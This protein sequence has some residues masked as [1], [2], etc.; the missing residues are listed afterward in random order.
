MHKLEFSP[1]GR[2]E[3]FAVKIV[4]SLAVGIWACLPVDVP[5]AVESQEVAS[6]ASTQNLPVPVGAQ[7]LDRSSKRP[8]VTAFRIGEWLP[9][10]RSLDPQRLLDALQASQLREMG[11]EEIQGRIAA[12][13]QAFRMQS[14]VPSLQA[15]GELESLLSETPPN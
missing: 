13:E 8:P 10:K 3:I 12:Y 5:R 14:L 6:P 1:P 7:P 11:D 2:L 9:R 4:L 15:T